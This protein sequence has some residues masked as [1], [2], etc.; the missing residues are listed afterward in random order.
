MKKNKKLSI[1]FLSL[2]S[3]ISTQN[4][5]ANETNNTE[6]LI[7]HKISQGETLWDISSKYF[8]TPYLWHHIEKNNQLDFKKLQIGE[9]ININKE[10]IKLDLNK[11]KRIIKNKPENE[12]IFS[13][14]LEKNILMDTV[15]IKNSNIKNY[16]TI[17]APENN[18]DNIG[19][20][21]NFYINKKNV[22]KDTVYNV[23]R[24]NTE[25]K[26]ELFEY[27]Q[28][29][30]AVVINNLENISLLK[31]IKIRQTINVND[32]LIEKN[33]KQND[34]IKLIHDGSL[35]EKVEILS[36]YKNAEKG[37]L[38]DF[39][40]LDKSK[41]NIKIGAIFKVYE[42]DTILIDPNT[43]EKFIVNG[44]EKGRIA[45]TKVEEDYMI[46]IISKVNKNLIKGDFIK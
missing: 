7:I 1:I 19:I 31:T 46:G 38:F 2:F 36:I 15:L 28:I 11:N 12:N 33:E 16:K 22:K 27:S 9:K 13:K 26:D 41:E 42:N 10:W 4:I 14:Y 5:S 29:G 17:I 3:I 25:I 24:K 34:F 43:K 44:K 45:I 18:Q 23:Y 32:L 8:N 21:D 6:S 35:K 20:L 39:V 30:E 37:T 40:I